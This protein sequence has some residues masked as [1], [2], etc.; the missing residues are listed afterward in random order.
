MSLGSSLCVAYCYS[1][2]RGSPM[3]RSLTSHLGTSLSEKGISRVIDELRVRLGELLVD[4]G[5]SSEVVNLIVVVLSAQLG[6]DHLGVLD[7]DLSQEVCEDVEVV[8]LFLTANLCQITITIA[9]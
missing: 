8:H 7:A 4:G 5:S 9:F 3:G 6:Q 2:K 1:G